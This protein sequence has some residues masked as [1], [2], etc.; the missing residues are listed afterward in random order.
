MQKN[1]AGAAFTLSQ[2]LFLPSKAF[3][4][5][6]VRRPR[7]EEWIVSKL[8]KRLNQSLLLININQCKQDIFMSNFFLGSYSTKFSKKNDAR[9]KKQYHHDW[10]SWFLEKKSKA[11]LFRSHYY[12]DLN[13]V[14]LKF[15]TISNSGKKFYSNKHV[16]VFEHFPC[17]KNDASLLI[18]KD[19]FDN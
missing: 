5:K 17:W 2:N 19:G 7:K 12:S 15:S 10:K 11:K 8:E 16:S 3:H 13:Y 9:I 4:K 18:D 6:R 14:F 1:F